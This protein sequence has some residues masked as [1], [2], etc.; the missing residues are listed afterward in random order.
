MK[1]TLTLLFLLTTSLMA[2]E[3]NLIPRPTKLTSRAGNFTLRKAPV[4]AAPATLANEA[5]HLTELLTTATGWRPTVSQTLSADITLRLNSSLSDLGDEGYALRVTPQ[6][7]LI[8]AAKPAGVF[9]GIQ[10]LRQ[11]L[12]VEIDSPQPVTGVKWSMPCVEIRDVPRFGWRGFMLDSCRHFQSVETVKL[13]IDQMA[14]QKINR[15]HWH[16]TEDEAWRIEVPG[17][18]ELTA[19]GAWRSGR[20]D[21]KEVARYGG[22]YSVKDIK[23]IVAYARLRH[24]LVYPE[25]E[26]PGHSTAAIYAYPQ[27]GCDGKPVIPG[28]PGEL[29][30][31]SFSANGR[32]AFCPSRPE[33]YQ[34]L[35]D[36]SLKISALF[37]TPYIHIGAD[38]VPREQWDQCPRC[39]A[40]IEKEK[41]RDNVGL[42]HFFGKRMSAFLRKHGKQPI[43]WGVDLEHGI[44]EGMIVQGWHPGESAIAAK[45]GFGTINSDCRGTYLDFPAGPADTGYGSPYLGTL[46]IEAVYKF[47]PVPAGLT[48]EQARLVMGSEAALWTEYVPEHKLT[49]KIFPRMFAF[50][51]IV[52]SERQPRDFQEFKQ[53][54]TP[55]LQRLELVNIPYFG[56]QAGSRAIGTWSPDK[57]KAGETILEIDATA[58]IQKLPGSYQASFR[59]SGGQHAL[60]IRSVALLRAGVE[61]S[62]DTHAGLAG[63]RHE[64]QNYLLAIPDTKN[65]RFTLR[66]TVAGIGGTDSNGEVLLEPAPPAPQT[67]ADGIKSSSFRVDPNYLSRHD[68]V[69]QSPMQLEAEG[70]P[71]GNGDMGGL[72]WTHDNGIELQINKND[73]WSGPEDGNGAPNAMCVPRHCARVK[74]D[75]GMPVFSWTHLVNDF[76]GRL[77]LVKGEASFQ[78]KSGFAQTKVRSWLPQD[79]NVWVIECENAWNAKFLENGASMARVGLERLGSRAFGGW[80]AGGF[81]RNPESGLTNTATAIVGRDMILEENSNNMRFTVACRIL[82]ADT[83]PQRLNNHL[84]EGLISQPRFT[85]LVSVATK[86][87]A[88]DPR[89]AAIALLDNAERATVAKLRADKDEW[90]AKFWAKSFVKLG[91]DYLE[92]IYYLRRY[93]MGIGSRGKYPVVFNGGLWRWN[94]DVINWITPHHWNTQQQYWGL[95]VQNDCDLM[96]PYLETYQR[97]AAQPGMAQLA[98]R[99]GAP[100]DAILLAEMHQFDGTMVDADRGDMKNA[101]TQAA[102]VASR[103]WETYEFT[104]D[105]N[106][107][108]ATAYPFMKKAANFYLQKLKWDEAKKV[109]T[110]SGSNYEDGGGHGP[111]PNPVADRVCIE[112]LFRSCTQAAAALKTDAELAKRWQHVLDH[113]W[114]FRL[115]TEK[116]INGEVIA[117]SDVPAKYG[118]KQWALGGAIAFPGG[119]IGVNHKDTPIGKA[120][121]TYIRS[122]NGYMYSHHPTPVIAARMGDGDEA[123][124]LLKDGISEMQYFPSGLFFNCRGYPSKLYDLD[125]KVNL[126]GGPGRPTIKWRDFFQCGM[127]TISLC[128]T[129]MNEMMMQSNEGKIRVFPAIPGEWKSSPLAFKLLARN[130]FLVSA[131]RKNGETAQV[132]IQSQRG[133]PCRLQNPWP[134]QTSVVFDSD[135]KSTPLTFRKDADDVIGFET[136]QGREYIV[137]K[138]GVAPVTAPTIFTASPN[139][140]PKKLGATRM[141]GIGKG[142]EQ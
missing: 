122:L 80:Y 81:S 105:T 115:V 102:Q 70:F 35:E 135:K 78:A 38:E 37:E 129:A 28:A 40:F 41:L 103:F 62:R 123:L 104:G 19:K 121:M 97:M 10:T 108:E 64:N 68:V 132:T 101:H 20:E 73:V 45:N 116:D 44:P 6:G 82:S 17:Y 33:T 88:A 79:R 46:P 119:I 98:A 69:Y 130:G 42:Q 139:T 15:L 5:R 94:R 50:A 7:A 48:P 113:L 1:H 43:Y 53:R 111:V 125:L 128:G 91:D 55:H 74:V 2:A 106:Y 23:E 12:P 22:F 141:L 95:C 99:R 27:Y 51:E 140:A 87:D 61:V 32:R 120:V 56:Q 90:F 72:I 86:D 60:E 127:E 39:K 136:K 76:E 126:I 131:E 24:V 107:L 93:L 67:P 110:M 34:F 137:I 142:F 29:G 16:L 47:E 65:G 4:I 54:M 49:T 117:T 21:G 77:S 3:V 96:R 11:L 92:N 85:V 63:G 14:R 30:I 26:M 31:A 138:S 13:V 66:A 118:V 83:T 59:F 89:A 133:L 52:W 114:E 58:A 124:K 71:L 25:I 18:P 57:L 8:E 36:V 75:F 84:A 134:G 9:Y 112:A 100:N 109:F